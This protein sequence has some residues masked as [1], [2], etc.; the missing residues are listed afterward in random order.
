MRKAQSIFIVVLILSSS[1]VPNEDVSEVILSSNK[2]TLDPHSYS[3]FQEINTNHLHLDLEI[4][5]ENKTIY[6]V[7]RHTMNNMSNAD[8][9]TFD[10]KALN[11]Q[12]VTLGSNENEIE[13]NFEIGENHKLKGQPLHVVLKPGSKQVNMYY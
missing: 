8:T 7:A 13:T 12:K 9:A 2:A 1:C 10:I 3:N 5:F 4:N 11:I 6:G